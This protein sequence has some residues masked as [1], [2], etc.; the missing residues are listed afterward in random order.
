MWIVACA[1]CAVVGLSLGG[2]GGGGSALALPVLVYIAG[3]P[4][5]HAV[6]VSAMIVGAASAATIVPHARRGNVDARTAAL[7]GGAGIPSAIA[8]AH[9]SSQV[10]PEVL[11]GSFSL[12]LV[13]VAGW[14]MFGRVPAPGPARPWPLV[15]AI[16]AGVGSIAGFFGVGGGFMIVPAL[17]GLAGLEM[18]RAIGTSLLVI[19]INSGASMVEHVGRPGLVSLHSV[20]FTAAAVAGS[21]AGQHL[22]RRVSVAHLRRAFAALITLVAC[23]VAWRVF[24]AG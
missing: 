8:A 20:A 1:L 5:S 22:S 15:A 16:G 2:L 6:A 4:A 21:L 24:V 11:L 14:M 3:L 17:I 7:F 10:A 12:L 19:A 13:G 9:L 23:L 18:R